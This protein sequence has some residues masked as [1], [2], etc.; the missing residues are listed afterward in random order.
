[1]FKVTKYVCENVECKVGVDWYGQYQYGR[2]KEGAKKYDS[3]S[4]SQEGWSMATGE[5]AMS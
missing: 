2:N 1:M 5:N 4:L 3:Q